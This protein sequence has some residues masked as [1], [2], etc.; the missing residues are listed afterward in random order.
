MTQDTEERLLTV[1]IKA[2]IVKV[3]TVGAATA[4]GASGAGAAVA[5]LLA[6]V[7][8]GA[9]KKAK[10]IDPE[11]KA[12]W[13]EWRPEVIRAGLMAI[14]NMTRAGIEAGVAAAKR[15]AGH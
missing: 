3:G 10:E 6:P 7:L 12:K 15:A 9:H 4:T 2:A 1:A 14:P 11:G 13:N 5:V 8:R